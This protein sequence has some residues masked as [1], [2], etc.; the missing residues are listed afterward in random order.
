MI[1]IA[2]GG[3]SWVVTS[4][5]LTSILLILSIYF[6]GLIRVF[7][8]VFF[9]IFILKS[10]LLI[11]FFR[12]PKRTI[13]HGV[14]AVADGKIRE[15][16][17]VHD[18][19]VGECTKISTFMNLH[20]VHVNRM[21]LDGRIIHLTHHPGAHVPAFQKESEKNERAILLMET[22]IG[23]IKIVQ[24]AGTLARRIVPYVHQGDV[25]KKG[26]KIG[27]IR[28]GSRVDVYLPTKTIKR[29]TVTLHDTIKAGE[30]TLAELIE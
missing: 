18:D 1:H 10:C 12:D 28:L 29:V 19:E 3:G 16:T 8:L 17:T 25:L 23:V 26:E 9:A 6:Q 20:N 2:K 30:D 7:L 15:I 14:V 27:L 22:S 11:I 21:P 13:S 5:I 24:I 4:I